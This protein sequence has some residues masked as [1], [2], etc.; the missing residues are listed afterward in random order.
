MY[1]QENIAQL[2]LLIVVFE[3]NTSIGLRL[4][5]CFNICNLV[6]GT[7]YEWTCTLRSSLVY[8]LNRSKAFVPNYLI[9]FASSSIYLYI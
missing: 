8:L 4:R 2:G 3:Y 1:L 7:K 5:H 9:R 6:Y